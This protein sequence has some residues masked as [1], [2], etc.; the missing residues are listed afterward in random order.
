MKIDPAKNKAPWERKVAE[1]LPA[2]LMSVLPFLLIYLSSGLDC[3]QAGNFPDVCS[4]ASQ[5]ARKEVFIVYTSG[6]KIS[7]IM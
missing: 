3:C 4:K 1:M 5:A 2:L 7:G 6:N